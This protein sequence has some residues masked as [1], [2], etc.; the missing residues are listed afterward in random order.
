MKGG[1]SGKANLDI[2][3]GELLFAETVDTKRQYYSALNLD[4]F[5]VTSN[6]FYEV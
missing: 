5:G 1:L 3:V 2:V 6:L 4:Y